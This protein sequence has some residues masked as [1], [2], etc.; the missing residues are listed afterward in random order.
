MKAKLHL[1]FILIILTV[2][3]LITATPVAAG[4]AWAGW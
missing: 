4:M 1:V 3:W 2:L